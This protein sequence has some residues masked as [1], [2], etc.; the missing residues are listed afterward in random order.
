MATI[1]YS[2]HLD[3]VPLFCTP[4]C[5]PSILHTCMWSLYGHYPL[6]CT[7][8]CGLISMVYM[9]YSAHLYVGRLA[10]LQAAGHVP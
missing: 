5:G 9:L 7:P 6:F 2:A 4:V 8:I 3:V 10:G 1:L